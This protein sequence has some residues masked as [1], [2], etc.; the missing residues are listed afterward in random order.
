MSTDTMDPKCKGIHEYKYCQI[1][2]NKDLFAAVYLIK[3]KSN[4]YIS[5]K[6]FILDYSAVDVMITDRSKEQTGS[7]TEF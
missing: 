5:L 6:Q 7:G 2:R 1:F 3:K 4:C